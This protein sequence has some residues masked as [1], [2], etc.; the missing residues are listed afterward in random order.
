MKIKDVIK[1]VGGRKEA[2]RLVKRM[3]KYIDES[4]TLR[5][6][7]FSYGGGEKFITPYQCSYSVSYKH[8]IAE[9]RKLEQSE[10]W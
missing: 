4:K 5:N 10:K 9:L 6:C 3:K 2:E 7:W 1:F 8:I